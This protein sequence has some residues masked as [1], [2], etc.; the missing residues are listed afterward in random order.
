MNWKYKTH[1]CKLAESTNICLND[2]DRNDVELTESRETQS[3]SASGKARI[4]KNVDYL[5][6]K[7]WELEAVISTRICLPISVEVHTAQDLAPR[8]P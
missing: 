8:H 5:Q 6:R 4:L 7:D 3:F 1:S 2:A